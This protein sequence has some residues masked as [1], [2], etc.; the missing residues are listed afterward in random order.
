MSKS[1]AKRIADGGNWSDAFD[2]MNQVV[3]KDMKGF[4][5]AL[6]KEKDAKPERRAQNVRAG[7]WPHTMDARVWAQ[8]WLETVKERPEVATDEGAMI[9]WFA[10]AIMAGYDAAPV[11]EATKT[12]NGVVGGGDELPE[13]P[14]AALPAYPSMWTQTPDLYTAEQMLAIRDAGI[15]YGRR[16]ASTGSAAAPSADT[17][18]AFVMAVR[19]RVGCHDGL[20]I[21]P[22]QVRSVLR[23]A[24]IE[25]AE[26]IN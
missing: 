24:R 2:Y 9:G 14:K 21:T 23:H 26:S 4:Y 11:A 17:N 5:A 15:E 6:R 7:I 3:E 25:S 18:E 8:K 19:H 1:N 16:L 22:A 12:P 13:L 10:N 20:D